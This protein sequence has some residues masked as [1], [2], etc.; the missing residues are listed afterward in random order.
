MARRGVT[1]CITMADLAPADLM[2]FSREEL[3]ER[4][5]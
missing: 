5:L 1:G 4:F 2:P 3:L